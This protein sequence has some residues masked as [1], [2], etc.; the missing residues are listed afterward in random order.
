[1]M[2]SGELKRRCKAKTIRLL[3][4]KSGTP[5]FTTTE[6]LCMIDAGCGTEKFHKL[7][8]A[9]DQADPVRGFDKG[10]HFSLP[11]GLGTG[12]FSI[13]H[14]SFQWTPKGAMFIASVLKEEDIDFQ[15]PTMLITRTDAK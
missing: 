5:H 4:R 3:D 6:A 9:R 1:M 13:S 15:L 12:T 14:H 2:E 11:D 7:L 10:H 8:V